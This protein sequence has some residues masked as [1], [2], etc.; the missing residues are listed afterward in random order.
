MNSHDDLPVAA[1]SW[2]YRLLEQSASAILLLVLAALVWMIVA[3]YIPEWGR[4]ASL[5][6]E[7]IGIVGLLIAA[8]LLVS[9]VA[10][11]HTRKA[12]KN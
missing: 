9:F 8:L 1:T 5:E 6:F 3:T 12:P 11:L 10:L 2:F 4:L 7:I